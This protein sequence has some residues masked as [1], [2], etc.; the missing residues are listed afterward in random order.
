MLASP[1]LLNARDYMRMHNVIDAMT[2]YLIALGVMLSQSSD[3]ILTIGGLVLLVIRL[4]ADAPRAW[5]NVKRWR[6]G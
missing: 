1:V 5:K 4:V 3:S 6:N 2:S